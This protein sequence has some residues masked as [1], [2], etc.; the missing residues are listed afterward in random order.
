MPRR[1]PSI[2]LALSFSLLLGHTLL[3]HAHQISA[4][5]SVGSAQP[6]ADCLW[7]ALER[8]LS[9]DLGE[10]HLEQYEPEQLEL[11]AGPDLEPALLPGPICLLPAGREPETQAP[12][13]DPPLAWPDRSGPPVC[14][15]GPPVCLRGPPREA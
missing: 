12:W 11:L 1:A 4:Q 3:P 15:R 13:P 2:W 5:L 14:L 9:L 8:A 7:H 10:G 6:A